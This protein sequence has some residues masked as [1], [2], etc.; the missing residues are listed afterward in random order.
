[1]KVRRHHVFLVAGV[2]TACNAITGAHDRFLDEGDGGPVRRPKTDDDG[3]P[4]VSDA[5]ASADADVFDAGGFVFEAVV[6]NAGDWTSPNGGI[7]E[8]ASGGLLITGQNAALS[9]NHP[10][11]LPLTQPT[12]PS[13]D[14]TVTAVFAVGG[15]G[16]FGLVTRLQGDGAGVLFGSKFGITTPYSPFLGTI[17]PPEWNPIP[18][19]SAARGDP[20]SLSIGDDHIL[21]VKAMGELIHGRLYR[22]GGVRPEVPARFTTTY[23]TGGALGIYVYVN[24][25]DGGFPKATLKSMKV[26]VP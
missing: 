18:G 22:A 23:R 19:G 4:A 16:E 2:V 12:V 13:D 26:T 11:I 5:G 9:K 21:E 15:E 3:G 20:Y 14:Y 1:M 7:V 10:V 6:G 8:V 25:N 17:G 24:T